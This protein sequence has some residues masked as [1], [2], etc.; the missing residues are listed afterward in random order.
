[1]CDTRCEGCDSLCDE[2]ELTLVY[3]NDCVSYYV[4]PVCRDDTTQHCPVC[5][6]WFLMICFNTNE[7]VCRFCLDEAED[8][9]QT[10]SEFSDSECEC[11][12][13]DCECS[14]FDLSHAGFQPLAQ[15]EDQ[16]QYSTALATCSGSLMGSGT[17]R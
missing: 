17:K 14:G 1:M 5:Q 4:C 10:D 16:R 6:M 15:C 9:D 13:T 2:S 3:D 7:G 12:D 11:S 8:T